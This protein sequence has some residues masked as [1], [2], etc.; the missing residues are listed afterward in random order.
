MLSISQATVHPLHL[1]QFVFVCLPQS[2]SLSIKLEKSV[3]LEKGTYGTVF[4]GEWNGKKVAVKRI[5]KTECE[6]NKEEE[7]LQ[8]LD[9]PNVVKL[10]HVESDRNFR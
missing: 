7:A 6:N 10:Y 4:E 9:H 3:I 1:H 8:K 5:E 2:V